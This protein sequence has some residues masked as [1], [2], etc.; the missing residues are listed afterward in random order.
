M[1]EWILRRLKQAQRVDRIIVATS[2]NAGDDAIV[3]YCIDA[4]VS[5]FR[6]SV[7]NVA[8]RL[9]AAAEWFGVEEFVRISG[10]SPL[11]VPK[12]VDDVIALYRGSEV[13]VVTN[14]QRRTFPKGL[15][16]EAIRVSALRRAQ[17]MMQPGEAEHVTPVFYRRPQDFR[18]VNLTSGHEW[19][20]IQLAV[21]TID[22]FALVE[23]IIAAMSRST[24]ALELEE[25]VILRE[26]C[27]AGAPV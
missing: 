8:E 9:C 6:G 19:G 2:D 12:I 18:I 14:V 11:I 17:T 20:A 1:L 15:S 21:D 23:R 13:D 10:D 26:R 27:L 25:L 7:E 4:K 24:G 16:V 22:D 5:Y 3:R